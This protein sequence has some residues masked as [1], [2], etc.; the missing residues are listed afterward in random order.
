LPLRKKIVKTRKILTF[1]EHA[2]YKE[3]E[4]ETE[5]NPQIRKYRTQ[6]DGKENN[7]C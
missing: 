7:E 6:F 1:M 4:E 5:I 3:G 2:F